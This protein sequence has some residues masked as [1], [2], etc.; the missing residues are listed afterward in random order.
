MFGTAHIDDL[1][2]VSM[3]VSQASTASEYDAT[4][5][6]TY[7]VYEQLTDT[8]ILTG[9]LALID[10]ANTVGFY[11]AEIEISAANGF[12]VGKFYVVRVA[13]TVDSV[14]AA[15]IVERFVVRPVP[16][17]LAEITT[18]VEDSGLDGDDYGDE[19]GRD[20]LCPRKQIAQIWRYLYNGGIIQNGRQIVYR[21]G[22]TQ[23]MMTGTVT[24]Q[25]NATARGQM[26][27]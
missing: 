24:I 9:S 19:P 10:D 25:A 6:P 5:S 18:V 16:V 7:R 14:D 13:A 26:D 12:E 1:I 11:G 17:T 27:D 21:D 2:P 23:T 8:P 4:G 20:N 15:G 22:S 3:Q